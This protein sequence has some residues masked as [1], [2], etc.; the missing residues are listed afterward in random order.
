[1][2][3]SFA[4]AREQ[5]MKAFVGHTELVA[6]TAMAAVAVVVDPS[7]RHRRELGAIARRRGFSGGVYAA[8]LD[9]P[10]LADLTACYPTSA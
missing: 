5:E 8:I 3:H 4:I 1:M 2:T 10:D 6:E 7:E 9:E